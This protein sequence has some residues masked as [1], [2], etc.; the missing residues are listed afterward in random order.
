MA[1]G[2]MLPWK[3]DNNKAITPALDDYGKPLPNPPAG[4]VWE[5]IEKKW[6]LIEKTGQDAAAENTKVFAE[7]TKDPLIVDH[8]VLPSDTMNG[9]CL[10]YNVS[11][12]DI[13]R[14]NNFSG[15]NVQLFKT[16]RI[17]VGPNATQSDI[18][19][20]PSLLLPQQFKNLTGEGS[21]E[22]AFYLEEAGNDLQRALQLWKADNEATAAAG[23]DVAGF[24]KV[25]AP[26][27]VIGAGGQ[28]C[29]ESDAV[30]V[31]TGNPNM[32]SFD[33]EVPG[34]ASAVV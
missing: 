27:H 4:H 11:A 8:V 18:R 5:F 14:L 32:Q 2:G 34:T 29:A 24:A 26:D 3:L 20:D 15:S 1:E 25:I 23:A 21:V 12:V 28:A 16:L 22:T 30:K 9:I 10:R 6:E 31:K 7:P 17:P 19:Q 13:R 33:V